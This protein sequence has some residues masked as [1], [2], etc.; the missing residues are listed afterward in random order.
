MWWVDRSYSH[1]CEQTVAELLKLRNERLFEISIRDITSD[2][3]LLELYR[4]KIPVI[5]IEGKVK[6]A[7][8]MLA[9]PNLLENVLR[10]ALL[11]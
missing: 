3:G 9:N 2:S 11:E 8:A 10:K 1:L 7:G 6:L 5:V 4:N